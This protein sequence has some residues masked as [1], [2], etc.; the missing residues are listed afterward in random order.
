MKHW[1]MIVLLLT[2]LCSAA[3]SLKKYP[4]GKSGCAYYGF[5]EAQLNESR[6]PDSSRIWTGGC[7][8]DSVTYTIICVKLS[9]RFDD[10]AV[11]E[12]V[13]ISY[14]DYLKTSLEIKKASAYGK[15]HKLEGKENTRGVI[16]YW[17]WKNG[18]NG[19]VKGWTDGR[20]I[21]V[22]MVS[23]KGELPYSKKEVFLDGFRLPE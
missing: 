7:T 21:G 4:I 14:M 9:E 20:F 11:A 18:D 16:D 6:S 2:G 1:M 17:E 13:L 19:K 3:Q 15:G 8:I 10:L 22:M 23:G 12:Q 5:C